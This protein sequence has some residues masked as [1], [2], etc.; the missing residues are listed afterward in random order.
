MPQASTREASVGLVL[1]RS[2]AMGVFACV[3]ATSQAEV[4]AQGSARSG[5]RPGATGPAPTAVAPV[6]AALQGDRLL[7]RYIVGS[8]ALLMSA[9]WPATDAKPADHQYR[10]AALDVFEGSA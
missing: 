3:L 7:V 4:S 10:V 1:I 5:E 8:E 2:L 6:S 9:A